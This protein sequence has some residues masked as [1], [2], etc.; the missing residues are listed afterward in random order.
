MN[1]K[2]LTHNLFLKIY[3][4]QLNTFLYQNN[5]INPSNFNMIFS[6]FVELLKKLFDHHTTLKKLSRKQSKSKLKP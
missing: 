5:D 1:L 2:I 3:T 4:N 6:D